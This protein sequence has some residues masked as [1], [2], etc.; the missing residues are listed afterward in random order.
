[1][2]NKFV[3][4]CDAMQSTK[5]E[6]CV[7]IATGDGMA[8]AFLLDQQLPI[9][10]AIQLH[11]KLAQ[12]NKGKIPAEII[13]I[14]IGL[15]SG[16]SYLVKDINGN[17]AMWGSGIIL[18]RRVMDF[19]DGGHILMTDRMA[20]ELL[21]ISD[22]YKK[23]IHEI[24]DFIIKH[25]QAI[26]VYSIYSENFGNSV[27]PK[28]GII[29]GIREEFAKIN[30]NTL[31]SS[32]SVKISLKNPENMLVKHTRTYEI[33]NTSDEP[34]SSVIHGIG[35]DVKKTFNQLK[36]KVFDEKNKPMK[37]DK[38]TMNYPFQKEFTTL[39]N[40]PIKKN[41]LGRTYTL[42]YEVE[43][44]ERYY[45]NTFMV[46]CEQFQLSFEYQS[47]SNLKT[48]TLY[49]IDQ[50]TEKKIKSSL[51]PEI[52]SSNDLTIVSWKMKKNSIGH[53]V[54]IEW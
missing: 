15:H 5:D 3:K 36:I 20:K 4:E 1:M 48:P 41:E 38:V 31:Y 2:L 8:I 6:N 49:E 17:L 27:L 42:E 12:Y 51:T 45:E 30:K 10:L 25:E 23:I 26:P 13:Q 22:E 44:P 18:A 28:A 19:G 21:E 40:K 33:I 46:D 43:E 11:E 39:F 32:A 14:R 54:R 16:N 47:K 37:I 35:I 24:E 53:T 7:K 34:I 29:Q 52:D 50:E 9:Q